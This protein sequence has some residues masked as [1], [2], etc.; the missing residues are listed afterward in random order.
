M[1]GNPDATDWRWIDDCPTPEGFR[2][3]VFLGGDVDDPAYDLPIN[4]EYRPDPWQVFTRTIGV[5]FPAD[6]IAELTA[7]IGKYLASLGES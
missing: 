7:G 1:S 6:Q 4:T 3:Q 2:L 5:E